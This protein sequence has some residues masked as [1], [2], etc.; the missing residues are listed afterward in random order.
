MGDSASAAGPGTLFLVPTPIGNPRDITLR[1]LDVLRSVPVIAAEDTRKAMTLLRAHDITARLVSYYDH[2]EQARSPQLLRLLAGGQD[3]ALITDAGTP[4]VNDPGYRIVTAAIADGIPV[5]PLPGP[6]A[7]ITALTGAGLATHS[8]H[9]A[10]YLPRKSAARRAAAEALARVP[11]TLI[12]FEAPHRLLESLGD[13]REVLG[14][15][16]AALARNLTKPGEEYLRGPLSQIEAGLAARDQV[17]G[18]YTL[19]VAGAGEDDG[20]EE[21]GQRLARSLLGHEVAPSVI[22][23]VVRDVAGLSRNDAYELVRRARDEPRA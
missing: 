1:A 16:D 13:L 18:E 5:R 9:Y 14:D 2:N 17:R 3:V 15:R 6:S 23:D 8:F 19:V 12:F 20:S 22:R 21:L 4:L 11:A 7:V 10:G